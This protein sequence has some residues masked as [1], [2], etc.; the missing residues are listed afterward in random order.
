MILLPI[1]PSYLIPH[2]Y[3]QENGG[4]IIQNELQFTNKLTLPLF[5]LLLQ[6]VRVLLQEKEELRMMVGIRSRIIHI[7]NKRGRVLISQYNP[8]FNLKLVHLVLYQKDLLLGTEPIF[9][10]ILIDSLGL[11][12]LELEFCEQP[13]LGELGDDGLRVEGVD[14]VGEAIVG[15]CAPM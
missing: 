7:P 13:A 12:K 11:Q 15:C 8:K 1:P 3:E 4:K 9:P 5:V 10:T 14:A 6:P 2:G